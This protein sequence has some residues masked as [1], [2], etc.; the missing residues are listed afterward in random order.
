M[1]SIPLFDSERGKKAC[2]AFLHSER[3]RGVAL[4]AKH[5]SPVFPFWNGSATSV[6]VKEA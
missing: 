2:D 1:I 6:M 4:P 5:A 3:Q